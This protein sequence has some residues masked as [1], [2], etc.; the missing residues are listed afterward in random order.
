MDRRSY[1]WRT[2]K[3]TLVVSFFIAVTLTL[4]F[5]LSLLQTQLVWAVLVALSFLVS[6][7]LYVV[8]FQREAMRRSIKP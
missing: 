1:F 2:L 5:P 6:F 3:R 7:L 4:V 8:K